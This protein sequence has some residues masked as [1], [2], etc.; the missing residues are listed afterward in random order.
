MDANAAWDDI[1]LPAG[2][3]DQFAGGT[4][5]MKSG[6]PVTIGDKSSGGVGIGVPFAG[7]RGTGENEG[8]EVLA[9]DP[10]LPL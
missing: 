1:V 6:G 4:S 5:S 3:T 10:R 8:A 7:D 9:N 2:E